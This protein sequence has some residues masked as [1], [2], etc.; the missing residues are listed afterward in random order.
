MRPVRRRVTAYLDAWRTGGSRD[1]LVLA[2]FGIVV[3][4]LTGA[5]LFGAWHVLMGWLIKGNPRAGAFGVV[6]AAITG[7]GLVLIQGLGRRLLPPRADP[8]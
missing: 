2:A 8:R 4:A 7:G 3:A 1:R 6:L 5:F